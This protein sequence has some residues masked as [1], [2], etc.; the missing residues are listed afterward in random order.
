M[1]VVRYPRGGTKSSC[2]TFP[3]AILCSL[4]SHLS[5]AACFNSAADAPTLGPS[6]SS[7]MILGAARPLGREPVRGGSSGLLTTSSSPSG[8]LSLAF[9]AA[10]WQGDTFLRPGRGLVVDK[11]CFIIFL[12]T[13]FLERAVCPDLC[14]CSRPI[15]RSGFV[16]NSLRLLRYLS[17]NRYFRQFV[18]DTKKDDPSEFRCILQRNTIYLTPV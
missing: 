14:F 17:H 15:V 2:D 13:N 7:Y 10:E 4:D 6:W 12:E 18:L 1:F 8:F 5:A 3:A 9:L 11:Y 16:L